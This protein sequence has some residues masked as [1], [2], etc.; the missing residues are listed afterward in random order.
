[1]DIIIDN[2]IIRKGNIEKIKKTNIIQKVKNG[3]FTF[4]ACAK[5]FSQLTPFLRYTCKSSQERREVVNFLFKL[6]NNNYI[7]PS[8]AE[9]ANREIEILKTDNYIDGFWFDKYDEKQL[10]NIKTNLSL[11]KALDTIINQNE[12]E[13]SAQNIK[14]AHDEIKRFQ[15][16][17]SKQIQTY[18]KQTFENIDNNIKNEAKKLNFDDKATQALINIVRSIDNPEFNNEE[19]KKRIYNN[20]FDKLLEFNLLIKLKNQIINQEKRILIKDIDFINNFYKNYN[21]VNFTKLLIEA[22]KFG[23]AY[24]VNNPNKSY[25]NDWINDTSYICCATFVD[26][27]LTNDTKYLKDAFKH[28]WGEN[29]KIM[30]LDEFIKEY[31]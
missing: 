3:E 13:L 7:F 6:I 1:M 27:L 28:I 30:T 21:N 10:K 8:I 24:K 9:I 22:T 15:E 25:D 2:N 29:K 5:I 31:C 14:S 12:Q 4:Y 23:Y 11:E 18:C 19:R 17:N 26:I 16:N 20:L